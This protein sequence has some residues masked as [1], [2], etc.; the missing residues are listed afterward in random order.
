MKTL[1]IAVVAMTGASIVAV[2]FSLAVYA[3]SQVALYDSNFEAF[4]ETLSPE[5]SRQIIR[6]S[7]TLLSIPVILLALTNAIWIGLAIVCVLIIQRMRRQPHVPQ[8][9]IRQTLD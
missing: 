5:Q 8:H 4:A 2:I 1:I 6:T 9:A 3:A 7:R